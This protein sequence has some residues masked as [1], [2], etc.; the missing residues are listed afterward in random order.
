MKRWLKRI[1]WT[2]F[3]L[4][5]VLPLLAVAT[6]PW[7]ARFIPVPSYTFDL[8]SKLTP[9]AKALVKSTTITAQTSLSQ[10]RR[11]GVQAIIAGRLFDWPYRLKVDVDYSLFTLSGDVD[12]DFELT[13]TAWRL[14]GSAEGSPLTWKAVVSLSEIELTERDAVIGT[15]LSRLDLGNISELAFSSTLKLKVTAE[16]TRELPV[17]VWMA[18]GS[19]RKASASGQIGTLPFSLE[20]LS[21][22]ARAEGIADRVTIHPIMPRLQR[23]EAA[24]LEVSNLYANIRTADESFMITEAGAEVC[25][26]EVKLYSVYLNPKRLSGGFTLFLDDIDADQVMRHLKGFSGEASGRLHGKIP[27]SLRNGEELRLGKAYLYSTP[28]EQGSL[29]LVDATPILNNLEAGGVDEE[30]RINLERAL[31]NLVYSVLKLELRRESDDTLAL[32]FKVEGNAT[33]GKTTVPVCFQITLRGDFETLIN[34]GI[35]L[36]K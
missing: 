33:H 18:V 31:A 30:T 11:G 22:M 8:D 19:V 34:T 23:I 16:K 12:F 26:G 25:G 24:G 28:G 6:L 20:N 35:R 29:K 5:F 32:G 3:V 7:Y 10:S 17:P 14:R 36:K 13:D 27:L 21:L 15:I 9:E 4:L 2:L 1:G